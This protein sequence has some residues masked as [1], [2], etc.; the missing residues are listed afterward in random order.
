M[1]R[2]CFLP[3]WRLEKK[4][5]SIIWT[6]WCGYFMFLLYGYSMIETG[7]SFAQHL[8]LLGC[9]PSQAQSA[10][11]AEAWE[12]ALGGWRHPALHHIPA[13]NGIC[14]AP[15]GCTT[16]KESQEGASL[17]PR[18][19]T[20]PGSH[21]ESRHWWITLIVPRKRI[22]PR[23]PALLWPSL[24][25][26][27]QPR[28]PS[29]VAAEEHQPEPFPERGACTSAPA[30]LA[31]SKGAQSELP[32]I[33][34]EAK[35]SR[36]RTRG[37]CLNQHLEQARR[38]Q[39]KSP[40]QLLFKPWNSEWITSTENPSKTSLV[41]LRQILFREGFYFPISA[42]MFFSF[43]QE[44]RVRCWVILHHITEWGQPRISLDP[45]NT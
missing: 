43:L 38:L 37:S 41:L 44:C 34:P 35:L 11:S 8:T 40:G 19:A 30:F 10:L 1:H 6:N 23:H 25:A 14:L 42:L 27:Q 13:E 36:N 7:V 33:T 22:P 12:A 3:F 18:G 5:P 28:A 26:L 20:A 4:N 2:K 45:R 15:A 31:M 39:R 32:S 24:G 16:W 17:A 21:K 29:I 9:R